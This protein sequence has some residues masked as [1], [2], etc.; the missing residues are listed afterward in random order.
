MT[1][2][3]KKALCD[4]DL[5][6][7]YIDKKEK[8]KV[9]LKLQKFIHDNKLEGYESNID[10][11]VPIESQQLTEETR[12]FIAMLYL[13]YWSSTEEEKLELQRKIHNN[14]LKYQE[15]LHEKYSVDN[16][17]NNTN[18]VSTNVEKND[19]VIS[20]ENTQL[21]EYKESFIKKI[22]NKIKQFFRR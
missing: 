12:A 14:E 15:E 11:K 16:I 4:I 1:K 6:L 10:V 3:Y 21:I 2:E 17:F 18:K 8:N 9:P 19:N 22:F 5:I 20:N 13:K 7:N